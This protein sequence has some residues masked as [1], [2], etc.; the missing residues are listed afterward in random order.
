MRQLKPTSFENNLSYLGFKQ[1][2]P[3]PLLSNLV[4]CYWFIKTTNLSHSIEYMHPSGEMEIIFNYGDSMLFGNHSDNA[5]FIIDG[6]HTFSRK[7]CLQGSLE[8]VGIKFKPAGA[9]RF[10]PI[11]LNAIKNNV[12]TSN[13]VKINKS[14]EVSEDIYEADTIETKVA[15]I[16]S[17]LIT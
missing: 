6:S 11:P 10:L 17:W 2:D 4:D 12:V 1:V 3:S 8:A 13:D 14:L 15:V 7:L 9:A 16:E 5:T